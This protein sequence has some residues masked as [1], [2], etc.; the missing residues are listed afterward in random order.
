MPK[1]V[2][3]DALRADLLDRSFDL[4]ARRGFEG[5]T[6]RQIA[7]ELDVSTGSLYHYFESKEAIFL[8]MLE[9]VGQRDVGMAVAAL[10]ANAN[11]QERIG[12]LLDFVAKREAHFQN[13]LFIVLDYF[14]HPGAERA[15]MRQTI[16]FYR[17]AI[18]NNL[19]LQD[20]TRA[21]TLLSLIIGHL[22]QRLLDPGL[23][24]DRKSKF[25]IGIIEKFAEVGK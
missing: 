24:F 9:H 11:V 18:A 23:S 21:A 19:G 2:D 3:H 5:L 15:V 17:S 22:V 14:R 6:I 10:P 25:G 1:I 7:E 13:L 8:Q 12:V 20:E 16:L 4:F